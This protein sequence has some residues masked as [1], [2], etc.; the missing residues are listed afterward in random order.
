MRDKITVSS[1]KRE[2]EIY[3]LYFLFVQPFFSFFV[4]FGRGLLT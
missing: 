4:G 3:M 2:K 1:G